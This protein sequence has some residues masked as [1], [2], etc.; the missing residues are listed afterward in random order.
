M[1]QEKGPFWPVQAAKAGVISSEVQW[2]TNLQGQGQLRMVPSSRL[3]RRTKE[4]VLNLASL[5]FCLFFCLL[6]RTPALDF[7]GLHLQPRYLRRKLTRPV[8]LRDLRSPD[9]TSLLPSSWRN[10]VVGSNKTRVPIARITRP[11]ESISTLRE[12][13]SMTK[14]AGTTH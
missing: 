9:R 3:G 11:D 10:L 4:V 14:A 2:S 1:K 6:S 5:F 12:S 8:L 13:F 7:L